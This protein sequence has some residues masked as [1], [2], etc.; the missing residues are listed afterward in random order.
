MSGDLVALYMFG[1]HAYAMTRYIFSHLVSWRGSE[2]STIVF[3]ES[4][5]K[6]KGQEQGRHE[7]GVENRLRDRAPE[8]YAAK[9][10]ISFKLPHP[11]T[12][13]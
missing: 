1:N 7:Q 5:S 10:Q 3:V 4:G 6:P 12:T 9:I 11:P 2:D 8:P 13:D